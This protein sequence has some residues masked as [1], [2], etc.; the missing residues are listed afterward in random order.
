MDEQQ[1]RQT[2]G[3]DGPGDAQLTS[4]AD[5]S[6]GPIDQ[7]NPGTWTGDDGSDLETRRRVL[8]GMIRIA[9]GAFALAFALPALAIR[10]L[11]LEEKVVAA[12]DALVYATGDRTGQPVNIA[13]VSPGDGVQVFPNGKT[14]N[15]NNLV[16]LV[17]LSDAD[18]VESFAAYSAICTHLGCTVNAALE[19][20]GNIM[21]PCHGSVFDP[22]NGAAVLSGPAGR[23]LPALPIRLETDGTLAVAGDFDGPV[24]PQ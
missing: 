6:A 24:G 11:S 3:A 10:T 20:D 15:P 22:A 12:G 18:A 7:P 9:Y 23:P 4:P 14:D 2:Q 16:E 8:K 19:G 21:C 17:R 5:D 13:D 1:E